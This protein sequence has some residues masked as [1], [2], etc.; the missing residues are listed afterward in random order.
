MAAGVGH[1]TGPHVHFEIRDGDAAVNPRNVLPK[2]KLAD[3]IY[4]EHDA[5]IAANAAELAA[6]PAM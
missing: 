6:A 1:S 2:S 3:V 4:N 5:A